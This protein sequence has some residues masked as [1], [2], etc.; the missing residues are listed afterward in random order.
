MAVPPTTRVSERVPL[1][2]QS[3]VD[4]DEQLIM[5]RTGHRSTAVREYKCESAHSTAQLKA[6]SGYLEGLN[7]HGMNQTRAAYLC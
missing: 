1:L 5:N 3:D 6:I 7:H 2:F 4:V